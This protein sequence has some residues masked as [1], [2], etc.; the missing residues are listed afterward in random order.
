MSTKHD[1]KLVAA[2]VSVAIFWGT[3]FLA[4]RIAVQ[5]IPPWYVTGF[6]QL[7]AA[8]I[9]V[10]VLLRKNQLSW[11]G[12]AYFG[13]QALVSSLMLVVANGMTTVAE[14]SIPSGLT[15]L[16]SALTPIFVFGA[17]VVVGLQKLT[18]R[19]VFGV[20]IGFSG[21]AFIFRSGLHDLENPEYYMGVFYL[22]IAILGWTVGTISTKKRHNETTNIYQNLFYQFAF[23]G[24]VQL[25]LA[26]VFSPEKQSFATWT[27][28]SMA[29]VAYLAVFGSIVGYFS[30]HYALA[31]VHASEV[32]IL[33]YINTIIAVF[34]G[35]LV[36]GETV[37]FDIIIATALII[38]GVFITNYKKIK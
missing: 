18:I 14:Q 13:R 31:R 4:I 33:S 27:L 20:L 11:L 9:M 29:A 8:L 37:T 22:L 23:A 2:L 3:T 21:V 17:S 25:L 38:L 30:Y 34:L 26:L 7:L 5:S 6:R 28:T 10:F 1:A 24:L 36:L 19:G 12:W 35:W 15:S 32:A 16:L